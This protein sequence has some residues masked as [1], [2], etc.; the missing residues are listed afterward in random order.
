MIGMHV[1]IVSI[2]TDLIG[3]L[4]LVAVLANCAEKL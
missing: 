3:A 4:V 2:I 1:L